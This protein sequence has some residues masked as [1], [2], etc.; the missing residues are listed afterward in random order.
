MPRNKKRRKKLEQNVARVLT[1][2]MITDEKFRHS[3]NTVFMSVETD[4]MIHIP[5]DGNSGFF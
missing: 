4:E 1:F 2:R 5:G 3:R